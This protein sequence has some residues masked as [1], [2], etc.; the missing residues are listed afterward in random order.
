MQTLQFHHVGMAVEN[1]EESLAEYRSQ[2]M[3]GSEPVE[4]RGLGVFVAFIRANS[5]EPIHLELV[6]PIEGR[7]G[8]SL[9][10]F[11]K[12]KSPLYHLAYLCDTL[13]DIEAQTGTRPIAPAT[14]AIAFGGRQIQFFMAA[15]GLITEYIENDGRP[16]TVAMP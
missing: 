3:I 12:Q 4:D 1:I 2:G 10:P 15:S 8:L 11:L 9:K 13:N 16:W 6:Q 5:D 7:V 14:K